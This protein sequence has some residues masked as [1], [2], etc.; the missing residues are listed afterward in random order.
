MVLN[1]YR[2]KV[3]LSS[4]ERRPTVE[5]NSHSSQKGNPKFRA[6]RLCWLSRPPKH[7]NA[8]DAPCDLRF[9]VS[10]AHVPYDPKHQGP[11]ETPRDPRHQG[12]HAA[13][14]RP[15][16]S[17]TAQRV[18]LSRRQSLPITRVTDLVQ[19]F[20][21]RLGFGWEATLFEIRCCGLLIT[22]DTLKGPSREG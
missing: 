1:V 11:G 19:G 14:L 4:I 13:T 22:Q 12:A 5:E 21:R 16:T 7:L 20:R 2:L 6:L 15:F 8:C 10:L 18:T 3:H 9:N 17:E